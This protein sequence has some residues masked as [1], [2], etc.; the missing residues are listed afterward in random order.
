MAKK[1]KAKKKPQC[2]MREDRKRCT[3]PAYHRGLCKRHYQWGHAPVC[4]EKKALYSEHVGPQ[5]GN[6]RGPGKKAPTAAELEQD[7]ADILADE[8]DRIGIAARTL[9]ERMGK[10]GTDAGAAAAV[11]EARR[12]RLVLVRL[13]YSLG[14]TR[15]KRDEASGEITFKSKLNG[16]TIKIDIDGGVTT[17]EAIPGR[18]SAMLGLEMADDEC[19]AKEQR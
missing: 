7:A 11:Q 1:P 19:R 8:D 12:R 4:A 5:V 14:N 17:D 3:D 13:A 6:C 15:M 9:K 2:R 10:V 16:R 18:A